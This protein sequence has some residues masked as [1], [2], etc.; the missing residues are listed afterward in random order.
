MDQTSEEH[1]RD[2]FQK[3]MPAAWQRMR[4]KVVKV[5]DTYYYKEMHGEE[6]K[7]AVDNAVTVVP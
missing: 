7:K 6:L 1:L 3:R 4:C 5:L 2:I